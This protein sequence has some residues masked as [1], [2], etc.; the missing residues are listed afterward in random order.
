MKGTYNEA[1]VLKKEKCAK[2][3]LMREFGN[4]VE[5]DIR[6]N[7]NQECHENLTFTFR[8]SDS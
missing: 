6:E 2:T 5:G 7:L 4:F 8:K 1:G 3:L